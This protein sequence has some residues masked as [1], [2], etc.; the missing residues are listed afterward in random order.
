[1]IFVEGTDWGVSEGT[2]PVLVETTTGLRSGCD[3]SSLVVEL[4]SSPVT[5][6][7]ATRGGSS[8]MA[9]PGE[10]DV[11][12]ED[13]SVSRIRIQHFLTTS[14]EGCIPSRKIRV[15]DRLVVSPR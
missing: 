3:E 6:I 2:S 11:R 10:E 4:L 9:G 15:F 13:F 12:L 8:E 7:R 5:D 1:M 14:G